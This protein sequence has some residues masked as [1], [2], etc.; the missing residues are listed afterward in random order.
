[1]KDYEPELRKSIADINWVDCTGSCRIGGFDSK[2]GT[3]LVPSSYDGAHNSRSFHVTFWRFKL[4]SAKPKMHLLMLAGGP[5]SLGRSMDFEAEEYLQKFGAQGLVVYLVDHRGLGESGAFFKEQHEFAEIKFAREIAKEGPFPLDH[6]TVHNAAL[7]VSMIALAAQKE[8]DVDGEGTWHV[9]GGSY[10]AQLANQVIRLTPNMYDSVYM[11]SLPRMRNA[12]L[13]TGRGLAEN[14]A[15]NKFC[16]NKLGGNVWRDFQESIKNVVNYQ[17]NQCTEAFS[18]I[19]E[20]YREVDEEARLGLLVGVFRDFIYDNTTV[21]KGSWAMES[22]VML[23]FLRATSD[24]V[25]PDSYVEQVLS[26][27]KPHLVQAF[28]DDKVYQERGAKGGSPTREDNA[29]NDALDDIVNGIIFLDKEYHS[30]PPK[31]TAPGTYDLFSNIAIPRVYNRYYKA[32]QEHLKGMQFS[33]NLPLQSRKTRVFVEQGRMDL[34]TTYL[35]SWNAFEGIVAPE[36]TWYLFDSMGHTTLFGDSGIQRVGQ[37]LGL[38]GYSFSESDVRDYNRLDY[39][40]KLKKVPE[41]TTLWKFIRN[42]GPADPLEL[43]LSGVPGYKH[44]Q[45][46]AEQLEEALAA[47]QGKEIHAPGGDPVLV[48]GARG[49]IPIVALAGGCVILF[50]AIIVTILLVTRHRRSKLQSKASEL[51]GENA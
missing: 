2:K 32:F 37:F 11:A 27:I 31:Y 39:D 28:L 10:G 20:S 34:Q 19:I 8:L 45:T 6:L 40:W 26:P 9:F 36:K 43:Q 16:R 38:P 33:L 7:D 21:V 22:Q 50:G 46:S 49:M 18:R 51:Q 24:C 5:G 29:A 30:G 35:P 15:L 4:S 17:T 41:V 13:P 42:A 14:C 48:E 44:V 1:M 25:D 47:A 12:I 3:I 23:L